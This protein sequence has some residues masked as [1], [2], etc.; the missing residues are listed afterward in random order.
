AG[1]RGRA[2]V[3]E[4]ACFKGC[5]R[6][7]AGSLGGG[8]PPSNPPPATAK[9]GRAACGTPTPADTTR[10]Q[11][12]PSLRIPR[13]KRASRSPASSRRLVPR[14]PSKTKSPEALQRSLSAAAEIRSNHLFVAAIPREVSRSRSR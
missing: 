1:E 8:G 2:V 4:M 7:A 10:F 14:R 3:E 12:D 11:K 9:K 5:A 6:P 13:H